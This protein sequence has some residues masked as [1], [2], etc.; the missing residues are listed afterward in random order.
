MIYL[1]LHI[2]QCLVRCEK[3][4]D[5]NSA[6]K[7]LRALSTKQFPCPGE[8]N[9]PLPGMLANP[10]SVA[11][12]TAFRSYFKQAREEIA[13]R[14]CDKLFDPDGSKNKVHKLQ[15]YLKYNSL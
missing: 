10:A 6:L 4:E 3:I 5:K 7:E 12:A 15:L 11:E 8:P 2:V 9:F 1:S 14:L 13:I